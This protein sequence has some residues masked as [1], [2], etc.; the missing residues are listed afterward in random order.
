MTT[1][2]LQGG[3]RISVSDRAPS[4]DLAK[5]AKLLA[6]AIPAVTGAAEV[7]ALKLF[8][9]ETTRI[10]VNTRGVM[11]RLLTDPDFKTAF[12]P[13]DE[14]GFLR[15]ADLPPFGT[16]AKMGGRLLH[17][18]QVA[19]AKAVKAVRDAITKELNDSLDD[20]DFAAL[21][22]GRMNEV[23]QSMA[24]SVHVKTTPLPQNALMV[25]VEFAET[26]RPSA[27]RERDIGRVLSGIETVDGRDWLE[28]MLAGVERKLR[29]DNEDPEDIGF[30]TDAIRRQS[31]QPD[32]Q[33]LRF[34]EFL[35]DEAMARVRLQVCLRIM[36]AVAAQSDKAGFKSYVQR[37]R[38]AFESFAGQDGEPL[39]LNVSSVYGVANDTDLTEQLR[40]AGFYGCLP[41]WC[42]GS[43]QLFERRIAPEQNQP[44]VREVSYRFRVNGLNPQTGLPAFDSRL[45]GLKERLLSAPGP[46]ENVKRPIA[47]L[48]FLSLVLPP[49]LH[50][51]STGDVRSQ[52]AAI[53]QAL[54]AD[55]VHELQRLHLELVSRRDLMAQIADEMMRL[56]KTRSTSFVTNLD[57][58]ADKLFISVQKDIFDWQVVRGLGS[59]REDVL[60]KADSGPDTVA[61]LS[62]IRV[63][64]DPWPSSVASVWVETNLQERSLTAAG[65]VRKVAMHKDLK[66]H[67]LPVRLVPYSWDKER[68]HWTSALP[69]PGT[70]DIGRGVDIEYD[71]R[72]LTLTR[73]QDREKVQAEQ[74]RAAIVAAMSLLIYVILFEL[75]R[76]AQ[77]ARPRL[78]M[79]LV[80]LQQ[81]GQIK[82][83]READAQDGNT[84]IYAISQ[85]VEKALARELPV[86]LQGLTT[87]NDARDS[88]RWKN[89]GALAA[90]QAGQPLCVP[91]EGSL[92][93]V[94]VVSYVTR[95]CDTHPNYPDADGYLFVSRT[96][97]A[98]SRDEQTTLRVGRM[99]SRFVESRE[100]FSLPHLILE[101]IARLQDR[102]YLHILL[103]S[104]HF[105]NRRIGRAAERHSPHSRLTFLDEAAK[106]F[107]DVHL[108]PLRRD[109]FAATR[110]RK[111]NLHESAFEVLRHDAHQNMYRDGATEILR[112]LLPVYTFATLHVVD[113]GGKPQSGFCTYFFDAE[114][115]L[116]DFNLREATRANILG[117]GEAEE[118]RRSLISV[119]RAIHFMESEKPS[120]NNRPLLPVLDPF[121][122][123]TP[124]RTAAAGELEVVSRRGRRSI[125]LSIPAL[126]AHVTRV[127]HQKDLDD[128]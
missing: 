112:S 124:N 37:V 10:R 55:P 22:A 84:A 95:P 49:S 8:S 67:V 51:A 105:G 53:A 30:I 14:T 61:W 110:L 120:E 28:L 64:P 86:K 100:D 62:R 3:S 63:S 128:E 121:A 1:S 27:E 103:L 60:V 77:S 38:E 45:D 20:L 78:T 75:V 57:R 116:S 7:K 9:Q 104:H 12:A 56:L 97:F 35:E 19:T 111:R 2:H 82:G 119:L 89:R 5:L 109:V 79:T 59:E 92:D 108:Y 46:N 107:P 23:L 50:E 66:A 81:T 102:G 98:D 47:E 115:R 42:E 71:L 88:L 90:L 26:S 41:V 94:A 11:S 32:S 118:T 70:L 74:F 24:Q 58:S 36:E 93:R 39:A 126:L 21:T 83:N 125:L 54:K 85:A 25:P 113:E 16:T 122:W 69:N 106:R 123:A 99:L 65:E 6:H 52:A 114:H 4:I 43:V 117:T 18:T 80:R 44:T 29:A 31:E 13:G 91:H 72:M 40:K 33:I 96:Y 34:L 17:G 76:K 15:D 68:G 101:E 87:D 127:L 73:K 48:V